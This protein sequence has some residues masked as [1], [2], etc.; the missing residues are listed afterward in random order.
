MKPWYASDSTVISRLMRAAI[1]V[2][3]EKTFRSLKAQWKAMG[4]PQFVAGTNVKK[5]IEA[6]GSKFGLVFDGASYH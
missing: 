3:A 6:Y 4:E 2:Q 1:I 5:V